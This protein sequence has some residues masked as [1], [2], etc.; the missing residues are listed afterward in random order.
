M[1]LCVVTD[2][3]GEVL[4]SADP[5]ASSPSWS[6]PEQID[7]G[8]MSPQTLVSL[9]CA[10]QQLCVAVDSRGAELTS[11]DPVGG[12]STWRSTMIDPSKAVRAI[13][14]ASAALCVAIDESGHALTSTNPGAA[15]SAWN[16]SDIDT[17]TPLRAISCPT[18]S[19]C[20]AVDEA[21]NVLTSTDPGASGASWQ[22]HDINPTGHPRA[23]SCS[24]NGTCVVLDSL[25]DALASENPASDSPTWSETNVDLSGSSDNVSCTVAGFCVMVDNRGDALAS[26]EPA[27]VIPSW[28]KQS[29]DSHEL[30]GVSCV[31]EGFCSAIDATGDVLQA[32]L[33]APVSTAVASSEVA[34]GEEML[35][36]TVDPNGAQLS[37]CHFEY[38]MSTEYGQSL[39]CSNQPLPAGG[40]QTVSARIRG[41]AP[42]TTYH[43][44]V[45]ATNAGG[46]GTAADQTFTTAT[47]AVIVHPV[48]TIVG[49]P[50]VG[51]RLRCLTGVASTAATLTYLWSRD[52]TPISG[53]GSAVYEVRSGDAK[54]HLRCRVTATDTAGSA[55]A[56]SAFVA[57]PAQGIVA[58]VGESTIGKA[59]VRGKQVL[60]PVRCS[61]EA[62]GACTIELRLTVVET[63]RNNRIVAVTAAQRSGASQLEVT[64]ASAREHMSPGE[65]LTVPMTLTY[66]ARSLLARMHRLPAEL[67]VIGTVIG[68]LKASLAHQRVTLTVTLVHGASR[69][70]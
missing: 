4:F 67:T 23:I 61:S 18:E 42:A 57:I 34:T 59:V 29:A 38:G 60:V 1:G 58:S 62:D 53:T 36:G 6:P 63:R 56:S 9:S 31:S 69:R 13:S 41:L 19:L 21:G 30:L 33:P 24:A 49:V 39:P 47:A 66:T 8:L 3:A 35:T 50:A 46:T 44:R 25:G 16:V 27:A 64:I 7:P 15:D 65:R 26:D 43:F 70:I 14:C 40:T 55:S 10:S 11:T 22:T 28:S 48:P 54:H 52:T 12:A 68:A 2:Q 20:V 32:F 37:A 17:A 45:L 51:E 5:T